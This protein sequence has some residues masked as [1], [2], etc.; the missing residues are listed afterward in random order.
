MWIELE[1]TNEANN[2]S[3]PAP[4]PRVL[5]GLLN[6]NSVINRLDDNILV[7]DILKRWGK[8]AKWKFFVKEDPVDKKAKTGEPNGEPITTDV[9]LPETETEQNKPDSSGNTH[10]PILICASEKNHGIFHFFVFF[11]LY[12]T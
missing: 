5:K 10:K 4:S 11:L 1:E 7:M 6:P 9:H 12:K 3:I 2:N 8:N